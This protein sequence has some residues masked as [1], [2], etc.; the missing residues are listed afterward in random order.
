MAYHKEAIEMPP[1]SSSAALEARIAAIGTRL[2]QSIGDVL[3]A[4]PGAPRGPADLARIIGIDKVLASRVLKSAR[5]KDPI[6]VVHLS[7]GPDPLRRV[8]R[9]A[10][11]RKVPADLILAANRAVDE[12]GAFIRNEV[13]DR[14]A[15]DAIIS[16]WIPE[17]RAEFELRRKQS[18]FRATSELKGV[19]AEINLS[20]VL[21]HPSDDGA[22][23]DIVWLFAFFNLARLRPGGSVKFAT[24]RFAP[25]DSPRRPRTLDSVPVEGLDGLRLDAFCST[26]PAE[27]DV[28]RVG[29][30]VHYT[31]GGDS[32]GPRSATDLVFAEVNMAELDRYVPRTKARK[33]NVF[34]EISTPT[35]TLIFDALVHRDLFTGADPALLIY[36]TAIDGVADV[37]DPTRDIDRMDLRETIQNLGYG[38][39][40]LRTT[41]VPRYDELLR[42]VCEKLGWDG[43]EFLGHRCRIDYPPYG[44]QVVMAWDSTPP[45]DEEG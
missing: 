29:E 1:P 2:A 34:A 19:A 10:G 11:K 26:P 4:I 36:D 31:L 42:T 14:S 41:E 44:S 12:F 15:L 7:P 13:G 27:L 35:K 23:I 32:F 45:P 16:D 9:A 6:A 22:H 21:L 30:V 5:H 28:H 40:R 37:N 18:A 8:L 3:D 25:H 20:T 43:D 24:R 38:L 17:A 39:G 33:R